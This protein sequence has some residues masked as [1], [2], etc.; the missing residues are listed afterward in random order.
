MA[1]RVIDK[2]EVFAW[3]D[4]A[5]S[6]ETDSCLLWPF[7]VQS[8]GYPKYW[9]GKAA[10]LANREICRRAHGDSPTDVHEAAHSCGVRLCCNKRHLSWKTHADNLEDRRHHG[11]LPMGEGAW[12]AKLNETHVRAIRASKLSQAKIAEAYGCHPGTIQAIVEGRSW[13]HLL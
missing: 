1:R 7:S 12:N 13:K 10:H 3:L 11:T 8:R 9:D 5:A 4:W 2:A 6:Q